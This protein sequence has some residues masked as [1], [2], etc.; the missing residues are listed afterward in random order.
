MT[1]HE[2]MLLIDRLL[3]QTIT[4]EDNLILD[5]KLRR[6]RV[7]RMKVNAEIALLESLARQK[8]TMA[9]ADDI[10]EVDEPW[11]VDVLQHA[12][13][14]IQPP[15]LP[16]HKIAPRQSIPWFFYTN[17]IHMEPGINGHTNERQITENFR[18][19]ARTVVWRLIYAV[20][21]LSV[22]CLVLAYFVMAL[23]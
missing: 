2:E 8:K 1:D 3:S 14:P 16:I 15:S 17:D 12:S 19:G 18:Q 7:F 20:I 23:Y 10:L 6:E 21:G 11:S 13:N 9:T 22:S 4:E 5:D